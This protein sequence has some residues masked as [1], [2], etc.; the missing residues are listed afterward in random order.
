MPKVIIVHYEEDL[1]AI[2]EFETMVKYFWDDSNFYTRSAIISTLEGLTDLTAVTDRLNKTQEDIGGLFQPYYGDDVA[3]KVTTLLKANITATIDLVTAA[4]NNR[5]LTDAIARW[6]TSAANIADALS[7]LDSVN[8][9]AAAV[10]AAYASYQTQLIAE[11]TA[12]S[13]RDWA[14]DVAAFDLSRLVVEEIA[15]TMADGIVC[16]FPE[17]FVKFDSY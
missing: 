16:K 4:K 10:L 3:A 14:A 7:S 9:P 8:W 2:E 17:K 12:R 15:D 11:V 6:D 13:S 1:E 5:S